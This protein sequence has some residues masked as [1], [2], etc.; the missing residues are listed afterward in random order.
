METFFWLYFITAILWAVFTV[1]YNYDHCTKNIGVFVII[2]AVCVN[3]LIC[4]VSII[5]FIITYNDQGAR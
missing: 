3:I 5:A 4:P 1:R 2:F